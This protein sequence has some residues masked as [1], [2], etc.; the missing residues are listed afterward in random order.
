MSYISPTLKLLPVSAFLIRFI[1]VASSEI[2]LIKKNMVTLRLGNI[3]PNF[4][5]RYGGNL[6]CTPEV[7][8]NMLE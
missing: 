2:F 1:T 6:D 4:L 5:A 7:G 3:S 8:Q